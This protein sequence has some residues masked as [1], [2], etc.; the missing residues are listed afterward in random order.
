MAQA[1]GGAL[2]SWLRGASRLAEQRHEDLFSEQP[3]V[4]HVTRGA[5]AVGAVAVD[6]GHGP[7]WCARP[8]RAAGDEPLVDG[9]SEPSAMAPS[10][11][12]A[13]P[14]PVVVSPAVPR[15]GTSASDVTTS[16]TRA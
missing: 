8:G 3:G 11:T 7:A 16:A 2:A 12:A 9:A 1:T 14:A 4:V 10:T 6:G 15:P 13:A 5:L